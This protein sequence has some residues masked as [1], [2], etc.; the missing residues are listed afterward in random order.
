MRSHGVSDFPDPSPEGGIGLLPS[1]INPQTPAFVTAQ[2]ACAKLAVGDTTPPAATEQQITQTR[3]LAQCMRRHGITGFSDPTTSPPPNTAGYTLLR[4]Y[5]LVIAI[6][7]TVNMRS[8]AFTKAAVACGL[9]KGS[10]PSA[11]GSGNAT[12]ILETS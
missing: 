5:G 10:I 4:R 7:A 2:Q 3:D 11:G 12:R 6:P 8:P 9:A 1:S